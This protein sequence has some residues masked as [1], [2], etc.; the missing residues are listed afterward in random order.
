[1]PYRDNAYKEEDIE[2]QLYKKIMKIKDNL[3]DTTDD[4]I[5]INTLPVIMIKKD[6]IFANPRSGEQRVFYKCNLLGRQN[7]SIL[8][9]NDLQS[10]EIT[11]KMTRINRQRDRD[12]IESILNA[13]ET[14]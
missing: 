14:E 11:A 5:T 12:Y 10:Q 1:M 8:Y 6:C 7:R 9:F 13:K 4:I 2:T 3:W